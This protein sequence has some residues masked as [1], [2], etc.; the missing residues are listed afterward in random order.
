MSQIIGKM[1]CS[2][3]SK[4]NSMPTNKKI[5]TKYKQALEQCKGIRFWF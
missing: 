4:Y 2:L 3:Y 5:I 1:Q